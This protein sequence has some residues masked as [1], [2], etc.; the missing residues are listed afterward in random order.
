MVKKMDDFYPNMDSIELYV[1]DRVIGYTYWAGNINIWTLLRLCCIGKNRH[2][3]VTKNVF[4]NKALF[5]S[6]YW[7]TI[8]SI[9]LTFIFMWSCFLRIN[10]YLSQDCIISENKY[11]QN[12]PVAILVYNFN[13]FGFI[14]SPIISKPYVSVHLVLT[15]IS[16]SVWK[17]APEKQ[18]NSL[19]YILAAPS[20]TES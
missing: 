11:C 7:K 9:L 8:Y 15:S 10:P 6:W 4:G 3:W 13:L 17:S 1:I 12:L 20:T 14:S 16:Y 2:A 19:W 5:S 18:S